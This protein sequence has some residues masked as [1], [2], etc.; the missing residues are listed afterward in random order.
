MTNNQPGFEQFEFSEALTKAVDAIEFKTP[1][2]I[3]KSSIPFV[4]KRKDILA[5]AQTG[6]GKTAAFCFPMI[7]LLSKEEIQGAL[8]LVPTREIGIQI[9][10]FLKKLIV[11]QM[12]LNIVLLIGGVSFHQQVKILNKKADIII[13]T[14]GRLID[15]LLQKTLR[16]KNMDYLVL[17]EADRMLD[18]GFTSQLNQVLNHLPK[19]RQTLFFSATFQNETQALANK[20]LDQ[21]QRVSVGNISKPID[22]IKQRTLNTTVS[23]KFDQLMDELNA[24]KGRCLIFSKTKI[25]VEKLFLDLEAH[26][27][28]VI[29]IHGD[30][31]QKQ[32]MTA[33]KEF[34]AGPIDVLVA[35]DVAARGIDIPEIEHV[36]NYDPPQCSDDYIHRVGR[37]GRAGA[38]GEAINFVTPNTKNQ[39]DQIHLGLQGKN[40]KYDNS[41]MARKKSSKDRRN[42]E[43]TYS[44]HST[45]D[46][47]K[48]KSQKK[49]NLSLKKRNSKAKKR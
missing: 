10:D 9:T 25:S 24:K 14:P 18:M 26:G 8:I 21:P 28:L 38:H 36:V 33:I 1:T 37:T 7:E 41:W 3:Q 2:D 44:R 16:L 39:W 22:R 48:R 12:D 32:R 31:T 30:R 46:K 15:H 49:V 6:T 47:W 29:R 42:D 27:F 43:D 4:L 23:E 35:T 19:K 40:V 17:D 20:Y 34:Q 5:T 45:K 11:G 13:A